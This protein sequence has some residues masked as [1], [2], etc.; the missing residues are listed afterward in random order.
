M[1]GGGGS[2]IGGTAAA[3]SGIGNVGGVDNLGKFWKLL[4]FGCICCG[5]CCCDVYE[6]M[7][8]NRGCGVISER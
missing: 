2:C 6:F 1:D 3:G 5:G 4:F 7:C 8:C